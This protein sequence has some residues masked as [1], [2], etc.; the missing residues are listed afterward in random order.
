MRKKQDRELHA[1]YKKLIG[2]RQEFKSLR[3]GGYQPI[4]MDE[5]KNTFGFLRSHEEEYTVVILNNSHVPQEYVLEGE[6]LVDKG[7]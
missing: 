2:L 6:L 1:Y 5:I 3:R 7:E 4:I